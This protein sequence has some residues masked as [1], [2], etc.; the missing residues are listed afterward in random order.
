MK[1]FTIGSFTTGLA[2]WLA[3]T[4]STALGQTPLSPKPFVVFDGTYYSNKPDLSA[5]GIQPITAIYS[6]AFSPT[7]WYT[8]VD[9]LPS[10]ES[11][12]AA[13]R[14][15]QQKG[16]RVMIDIEHWPLNGAPDA[17][18][19]SLT[20]YL[21]VLRWFR[22]AAPGLSVGFYGGPPIIDYWRAVKGPSSQEYQS[23]MGENNQLYPLTRAVDVIFPSAYTFYSDQAGWKKYAIAQ[24]MEAR[25]IGEG[26]PVYVFLWPQY[27]ESNL[28]LGGSYLPPDYWLFEL[29]TAKKFADGIVIWG[30]VGQ[31]DEQAPWWGKT[32]EF[33]KTLAVS[34]PIPA[35]PTSLSVQ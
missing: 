27:H 14:V 19:N 24:I 33:M 32:K 26:K 1:L 11:V 30:G 22:N 16:H 23:W 2:I 8:N 29:E 31:W 28:V 17:V 18:L 4:V 21:T 12:Q 15:A 34:R 20:K 5:Y 25:R 7:G 3:L 13:A 35:P 9:L 10:V 6:G